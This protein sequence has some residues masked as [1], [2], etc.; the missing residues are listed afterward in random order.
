MITL[1]LFIAPGPVEGRIRLG[2]YPLWAPPGFPGLQAGALG[3][4]EREITQ[5][6]LP[7][8]ES[9]LSHSLAVWP[10]VSNFASLDPSVNKR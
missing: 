2:G 9:W 7:G 5:V 10:G 4:S 6:R 3:S 8:F 1:M